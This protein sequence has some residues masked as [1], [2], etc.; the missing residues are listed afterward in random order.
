MSLTKLFSGLMAFASL[1]VAGAAMAQSTPSSVYIR[2]INYA[3]TGCPAG[4]VAMNISPDRQAL[5]IFFASFIAEGGRGVPLSQSRKNCQINLDLAY[6]SGWQY[7][8]AS[9]DLRGYVQ[10]AR[11][12]TAVESD[13]FY[14]QGQSAATARLSTTFR[15]PISQNYQVRDTL[16]ISSQVWSPCGANRA[17]NINLQAYVSGGDGLITIESPLNL[18][19]AFRIQWR[20]C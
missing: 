19:N 7:T 17:L 1:S 12:A 3:G 6:P 16:G 5:E 10:L 20:R 4:T 2:S 15:G 14:F 18:N 9:L 13:T 8:V 11:G